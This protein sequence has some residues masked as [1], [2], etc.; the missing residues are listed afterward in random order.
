MEL[1]PLQKRLWMHSRKENP[2]E[3]MKPL[4][5]ATVANTPVVFEFRDVECMWFRVKN[6]TDDYIYVGFTGDTAEESRCI[7]AGAYEDIVPNQSPKFPQRGD[8]AN[9]LQVIAAET[10]PQGVE[11]ECMRYIKV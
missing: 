2:M 4:R 3:I 7:P 9:S 5:M 11:V 8:G 1:K 10:N 6:F